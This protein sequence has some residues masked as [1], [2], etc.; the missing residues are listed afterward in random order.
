[1][2]LIGPVDC[3]T[4]AKGNDSG[5]SASKEEAEEEAA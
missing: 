2:A 4:E 1:M 5:P 3:D